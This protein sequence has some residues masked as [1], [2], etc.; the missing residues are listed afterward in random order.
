VFSR[1]DLVLI[2]LFELLIRWGYP[3]KHAARIVQDVRNYKK[4]A[5]ENPPG[6]KLDSKYAQSKKAMGTF[7]YIIIPW[8]FK[9]RPIASIEGKTIDLSV[10]PVWVDNVIRI[11]MPT[12]E[13]ADEIRIINFNKIVAEVDEALK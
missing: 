9:K 5:D 13:N 2:K 3:R 6:I 1:F 11:H 8:G 10:I 7:N 4:I 12:F